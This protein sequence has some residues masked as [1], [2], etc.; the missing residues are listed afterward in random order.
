MDVYA[1]AILAYEIVTGKNPYHELGKVT[2]FKLANKVMR[3]YRP[4]FD[5][6][7]SKKMKNLLSRCW[8]ENI[9]QRPS[10]D[11]IYKLLISDFSFFEEDVDADE[12]NQFI[13]DIENE[14]K[15]SN[16]KKNKEDKNGQNNVH[17]YDIKDDSLYLSLN[18][19]L[20]NEK[21]QNFQKAAHNLK[22][23]S[24]EGNSL[25]SFIL[26]LIHE[27]G[28]GVTK[29]PDIAKNYYKQAAAQGNS[30]GY[31]YLGNFYLYGY[32]S[33]EDYKKAFKY[34][35]KAANLGNKSAIVSIAYCHDLGKGVEEDEKS[36]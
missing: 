18:C 26:A 32:D 31:L 36:S 6:T 35:Q 20:G 14:I 11:E 27:S 12:I 2:P 5:N 15:V 9:S 33:K 22:L 24:D 4:K 7:I 30:Y 23:A 19:L 13:E 29:N 17:Q 28:K 21:C 16:N 34:Y 25:A 10:F 1:F 8:D 3:G